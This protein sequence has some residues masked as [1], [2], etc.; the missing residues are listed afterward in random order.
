[1]TMMKRRTS[2]GSGS[3]VAGERFHNRSELRFRRF[4]QTDGDSY[5][6]LRSFASLRMTLHPAAPDYV[7]LS[8]E[9]AKDLLRC[10]PRRWRTPYG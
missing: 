4:E 6:F 3:S 2:C 1:M 7:I 8:R 10:I 5:R 9:E